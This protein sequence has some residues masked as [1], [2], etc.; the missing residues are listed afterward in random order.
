MR[1]QEKIRQDVTRPD[2]TRQEMT[3][4][5]KTRDDKRRQEDKRRLGID[6]NAFL[7]RSNT[8][9]RNTCLNTNAIYSSS[10]CL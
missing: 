10:T 9:L 8:G 3:R 7:F 1:R 4:Q 5:D 2:K 6:K